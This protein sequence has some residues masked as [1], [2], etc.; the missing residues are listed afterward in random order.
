MQAHKTKLMYVLEVRIWLLMHER[1]FSFVQNQKIKQN[2]INIFVLF[3]HLVIADSCDSMDSRPQVSSVHGISQARI[4]EWV[5][6]SVSNAG[7]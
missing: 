5:A 3:N 1:G 6:I 4:L 7:K 2:K